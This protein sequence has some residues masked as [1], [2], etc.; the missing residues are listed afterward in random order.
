MNKKNMFHMLCCCALIGIS[1]S[2]LALPKLYDVVVSTGKNKYTVTAPTLNPAKVNTLGMML[3][4]AVDQPKKETIM[5]TSSDA[6]G[7]SCLGGD[8]IEG[9][10]NSSHPELASNPKLVG[11]GVQLD[12]KASDKQ[13]VIKIPVTM[14]ESTTTTFKVKR[15]KRT[16]DKLKATYIRKDKPGLSE[17]DGSSSDKPIVSP[18]SQKKLVNQASTSSLNMFS[19]M[20]QPTML[21]ATRA[22]QQ[23]STQTKMMPLN[24]PSSSDNQ[25]TTRQV[26]N[27]EELVAAISDNFVNRIEFTDKIAA[28]GSDALP[29]IERSLV[30]DGKGNTFWLR[31][32]RGG[33][34]FCLPDPDNKVKQKFTV[35]NMKIER[36]NA[37]ESDYFIKVRRRPNFYNRR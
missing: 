6:D 27:Y 32:Y 31:G 19:D 35:T 22:S 4:I 24:N 7:R 30:I 1:F 15:G 25:G 18:T 37:K 13:V 33:D 10:L 29:P 9:F 21:K 28:E 20:P 3:T 12:I 26:K 5:I 14:L 2:I 11:G 8:Q 34:V 36:Q 17:G 23:L 16:V